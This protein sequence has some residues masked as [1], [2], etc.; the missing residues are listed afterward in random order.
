[1]ISLVEA[2]AYVGAMRIPLPLL[3]SCHVIAASASGVAAQVLHQEDV[4]RA[5]LRPG[6][7][8]ADGQQ[9]AA[10]H[11]QLAPNWKTYW[12]SPGDAGL[13]PEFDWS[14]SRNAGAVKVHW[15]RPEVFDF[16][17]MQ[18]IG[19]RHEVVL[20]VEITPLDPAV[21]V[22]LEA[23]ISLG[24]CNEICMPAHLALTRALPMAQTPDAAITAALAKAPLEASVAGLSGLRCAV[25]TIDDGLRVTATMTLPAGLGAETVVLE[26]GDPVWVSDAVVHREGNTLSATADLVPGPGKTYTLTPQTLR[27]TVLSA[28][29]AVEVTGC[30]LG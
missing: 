17:G 22:T 26:P 23:D 20:P 3:L 12:R 29:R 24:V 2:A 30:P 27:V 8:M 25:Q 10:L 5:E 1:M 4:L 19:Y 15:P 9:M 14:R 11:L 13:P 6:W 18:T 28:G 16:Q 7:R 21:P